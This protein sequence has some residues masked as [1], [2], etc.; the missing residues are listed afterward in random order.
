[1][2]F[3]GLAGMPSRIPSYPH[4]FASWTAVLGF[5]LVM[6]LLSALLFLLVA[7]VVL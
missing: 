3:L 5:G 1:M 4:A 2:H 6:C 7:R